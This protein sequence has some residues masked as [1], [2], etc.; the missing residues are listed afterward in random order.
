M[1]WCYSLVLNLGNALQGC[2][3]TDTLQKVRLYYGFVFLCEFIIYIL[4]PV[5]L[6]CILSSRAVGIFFF[7]CKQA[8]E[9]RTI[10][11]WGLN[12]IQFLGILRNA[13]VKV[14][15][16]EETKVKICRWPSNNLSLRGN[17]FRGDGKWV[18]NYD[19]SKSKPRKVWVL[20]TS[21]PY[22]LCFSPLW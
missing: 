5:W 12:G 14:T 10:V 9:K 6:E 3:D 4:L 1:H 11:R 13:F 16:T 21:P 2:G 20:A 8:V 17:W 18:P 15:K 22:V 19:S 7:F